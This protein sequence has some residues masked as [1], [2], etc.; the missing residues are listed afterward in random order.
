M[1]LVIKKELKSKKL[2]SPN[3]PNKQGFTLRIGNTFKQIISFISCFVDETNFKL[4]EDGLT[5]MAMDSSHISLINCFIPCTFFDDYNIPKN[6]KKGINLSI[7]NKILSQ[8][9]KYDELN[10]VFFTDTILITFIGSNFT[11]M[12]EMNLITKQFSKTD[13]LIMAKTLPRLQF[14]NLMRNAS[15]LVGNSSMGILEAP[16][17]KLPVVNIGNRQRGRLN[18]GN[19]EFVPYK[20][21]R[22]IEAL[23]KA[24]LNQ[25]Y[26]KKVMGLKNPFG[27]NLAP[28]KVREAIESVNLDDRKWYVKQKVC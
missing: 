22:I 7:F 27:D 25:E 24:T 11:K 14:V 5:I 9:G 23:E 10:I 28:Q 1:K 16:Y 4:T 8:L 2:D 21:D 15:A 26:K 13:C 3:Y 19:V 17:Y 6:I 18:A 20:I 12:Y